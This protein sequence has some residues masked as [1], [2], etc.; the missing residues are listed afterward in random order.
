MHFEGVY[1]DIYKD[2]KDAIN[3]F[4]DTN[5]NFITVK[6]I[7][8]YLEIDASNRSK[9]NFIW[10][11]LDHFEREGII[12]RI[13]KRSPKQAKQYKITKIPMKNNI[14]WMEVI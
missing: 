1:K 2:V 11:L 13:N 12:V 4:Y 6:R 5:N 14:T 8:R 7:R 9:I 3:H 10:R